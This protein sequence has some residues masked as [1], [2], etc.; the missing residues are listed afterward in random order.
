M[1][2]HKFAIIIFC[3]LAVPH[4][5]TEGMSA[6]ILNGLCFQFFVSKKDSETSCKL[7]I[8]SVINKISRS[9]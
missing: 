7:I 2:I 8:Y 9:R 4:H 5:H 6:G 1:L 3:Y